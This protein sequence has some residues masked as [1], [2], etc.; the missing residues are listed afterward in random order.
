MRPGA[1]PAP[2]GVGAP[3]RAVQSSA[4]RAPSHPARPQGLKPIRGLPI[5]A[6]VKIK[7]NVKT[8]PANKQPLIAKSDHGRPAEA[9]NDQKAQA[10]DQ[11]VSK[12]PGIQNQ[13]GEQGALRRSEASAQNAVNSQVP[14]PSTT[15]SI[16]SNQI[17][18]DEQQATDNPPVEPKV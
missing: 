3:I 11:S 18:A 16:V 8:N 12:P 1:P 10:S 9:Q 5:G 2:P 17:K 15:A 13:N 14:Q 4:A 7:T 6:S